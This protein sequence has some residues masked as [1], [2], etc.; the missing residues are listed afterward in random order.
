GTAANRSRLVLVMAL[1]GV[2]VP[3]VVALAQNGVDPGQPLAR[4]RH[5][6][7]GFGQHARLELDGRAFRQSDR[8]GRAKDAVLEDGVDGLA[9]V[10]IPWPSGF[11]TAGNLSPSSAKA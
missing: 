9:H 8:L 2:R 10:V 7:L 6:R 5:G 1:G 11:T 3:G 4:R